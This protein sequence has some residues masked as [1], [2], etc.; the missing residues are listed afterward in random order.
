MPER[1][2]LPRR[3]PPASTSIAAPAAEALVEQNQKS[4]EAQLVADVLA[5]LLPPA[6]QNVDVG[7]VLE[8]IGGTPEA[9]EMARPP[10]LRES[11][12]LTPEIIAA[13]PESA[14][15]GRGG[16]QK[17]ADILSLIGDV[18]SGGAAGA[19]Q[20]SFLEGLAAGY[21]ERPR[22]Q[23]HEAGQEARIGATEAATDLTR[24]RADLAATQAASYPAEVAF[25]EQFRVQQQLAK[26]Q[27]QQE[28]IDIKRHQEERLRRKLNLEEVQ[29]L[30][31]MVRER[32]TMKLK[33]YIATHGQAL[34][35]VTRQKTMA[36]IEGMEALEGQ[37]GA[38]S[39]LYRAREGQ[40]G[41]PDQPR[42]PAQQAPY[43]IM[44][45]RAKA[46][47]VYDKQIQALLGTETVAGIP[48]EIRRLRSERELTAREFDQAIEAAK[49][50]ELRSIF[51]EVE[52]EASR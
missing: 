40:L 47:A 46:L 24:N 9:P 16:R 33:E 22:R 30:D 12:G 7:S 36:Q 50:P 23:R 14:P 31:R 28:A 18:A 37:R 42:P 10:S 4:R 52:Q 38:L 17:G 29:A 32:Q 6:R 15:P 8:T 13:T 51:E 49:N 2:L 19:S 41:Q 35:P 26:E 20:P 43:Q 34:D 1:F 39:S 27:A 21:H 11:P 5:R 45:E 48:E 3:Q 44:A 25:E